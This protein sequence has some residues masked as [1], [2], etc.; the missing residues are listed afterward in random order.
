MHLPLHPR[1][2]HAEKF[3]HL[4]STGLFPLASGFNH[5]CRPNVQRSSIGG[6]LVFRAMRD[7]K[8]GEEFTISYIESEFLLEPTFIRQAELDRDFVCACD[9]L[10]GP[11]NLE[12]CIDRLDLYKCI[13]S[14]WGVLRSV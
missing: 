8:E 14:V 13:G 11:R 2:C 7:V 1:R 3:G 12:L 4:T 9:S 5:D 6:W 10:L